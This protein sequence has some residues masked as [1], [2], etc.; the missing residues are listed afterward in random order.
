MISQSAVTSKSNRL[1]SPVMAE[2]AASQQSRSKLL[3]TIVEAGKRA[4][5]PSNDSPTREDGRIEYDAI[6]NK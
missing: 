3:E 6:I 5:N 2:A 1:Q 4:F